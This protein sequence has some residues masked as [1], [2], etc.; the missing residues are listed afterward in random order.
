M[1]IIKLYD[2]DNVTETFGFSPV[3]EICLLSISISLSLIVISALEEP[4]KS[5]LLHVILVNGIVDFEFVTN[6]FNWISVESDVIVIWLRVND[7]WIS[8]I[9]VPYKFTFILL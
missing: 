9:D 4:V 1:L 5:N 3:I 7:D 8:L 2:E 6:A